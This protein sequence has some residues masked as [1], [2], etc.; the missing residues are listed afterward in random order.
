MPSSAEQQRL[1]WDVLDRFAEAAEQ[2]GIPRTDD[3]NTGNNEGSGK[4]EVTQRRG[5]RWSASRAFLQ[6]ARKRPNL[7]V[8]T[9]ALIDKLRFDGT[10][11]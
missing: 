8:V 9:G 5:W 4:F 2:A 6:P 7:R 11:G 3:F 1:R 10:R